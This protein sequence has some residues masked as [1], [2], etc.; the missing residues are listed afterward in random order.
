MATTPLRSDPPSDDSRIELERAAAELDALADAHEECTDE[1]DTMES[2]VDV[3][4]DDG[5]AYVLLLDGELKVTGVS[6]GMAR[7]LG[8][9][10]SVLGHRL[11]AVALPATLDT[12][13]AAEHWRV[14]PVDG[15]A[16]RLLVRRATEDDQPAVYVV[17]YDQPDA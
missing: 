16:G 15:G 2:T 11:A 7:L 3:L 5:S 13:T 4:L 12:L 9:E 14:L 10:E 17:R 1:L 8:G 6:R